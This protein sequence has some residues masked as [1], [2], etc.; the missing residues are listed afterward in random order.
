MSTQDEL[1]TAE[2]ESSLK[3]NENSL[4]EIKELLVLSPEE[5][6]LINLA[7]VLQN[8]I[9]LQQEKLLQRKKDDL[10]ALIGCSVEPSSHEIGDMPNSAE[11]SMS[12]NEGDPTNSNS[13][14]NVLKVGE[15]CCIPFTHPE[16]QK[17]YFLPG[18][19]QNID[20]EVKTCNVL[21]LTPITPSTRV[22]VKYLS[23]QCT[24][25]CPHER[26]HG[27]EISSEL[28]VPYEILHVGQM[29]AYKVGRNFWA[30][31]EDEVWYLAKLI[32]L[33][34]K[35]LGFRVTYNGYENENPHG[36]VVGP[37]EII[38]VQSLDDEGGKDGIFSEENETDESDYSNDESDSF[39]DDFVSSEISTLESDTG[40][41]RFS[42]TPFDNR[43]KGND[44]FAEWEKHTTGVASRM[45]AKMGYKMGEG[46]GKNG[47]GIVNPIEV[48][49]FSRGVS[50]DYIDKPDKIGPHRRRHHDRG[51]E[52]EPKRHRHRKRIGSKI[53]NDL[54][55]ESQPNVFDFLNVS[56]NKGGNDA[57][58]MDSI[59][60][61]SS[62]SRNTSSNETSNSMTDRL[63]RDRK[64]AEL[65]GDPCVIDGSGV[66]V[67]K[68]ILEDW[69]TEFDIAI[70]SLASILSK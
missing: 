43:D 33:E 65:V 45:M 58:D 17:V 44:N 8:L 68:V 1:S 28:V 51:T 46:L 69:E 19:I 21:I 63:K 25:I 26:S 70:S 56:L 59:N 55:A 57:H 5:P 13:D 64:P 14:L 48:K 67:D 66:Y 38:P 2:I 61:S 22:C 4:A 24:G 37:D 36:V 3:E 53:G 42:F 31:Y 49:L 11:I 12:L 7:E 10:L 62:S 15:K 35:G 18:L 60:V 50:L 52:I 27:E 6:E 40:F 34:S 30:K 54:I 23:N 47:E 16:N 20:F 9:K 29:D 41:G 32:G 39:S